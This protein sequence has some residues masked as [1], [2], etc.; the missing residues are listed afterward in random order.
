MKLS[1]YAKKLRESTGR[2]V[3]VQVESWA[4]SHIDEI[5]TKLRLSLVPGFCGKKCSL[6]E[7]T[8]IKTF[9][10]RVNEICNGS[11]MGEIDELTDAMEG[12]R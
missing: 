8:D 5:E 1:D 6:E 4:F 10:A 3:C 11:D 12:R 2:G 7:F 9:E